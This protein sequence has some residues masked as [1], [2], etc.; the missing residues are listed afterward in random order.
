MIESSRVIGSNTTIGSN[1]TI[2][3]D[4]TIGSNSTIGTNATIGSG[5]TVESYCNIGFDKSYKCCT[6][7]HTTCDLCIINTPTIKPTTSG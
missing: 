3:S 4:V 6:N 1:C 7:H 5:S 2:G